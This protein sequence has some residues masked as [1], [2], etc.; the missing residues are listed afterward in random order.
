LFAFAFG[1]DLTKILTDVDDSVLYA[2]FR[3]ELRP[4]KSK[5]PWAGPV[6]VKWKG[7]KLNLISSKFTVE[8]GKRRVVIWD[9]FRF[10]AC[11]FTKALTDWKVADTKLLDR[12]RNMKD[13]RNEFDKQTPEEIRDYCYEECRYMASLAQKLITAHNEAGL[14]LRSYFGAGSSAAAMLK[15]MGIDKETR[16]GPEEMDRAVASAFFGGRFEN[17]RI[18]PV[19]QKL[20]G[21]DL[22]SAYILELYNL[23]CLGC[24]KWEYTT[25]RNDL[26]G[27]R[28]AC[29]EYTLGDAPKNI[30]WG[31]LPFR[32]KNGSIV[33]PATSGGGWVWLEEFIAAERVYPH[34]HFKGAWVYRTDC[35]HRPFARMPDWYKE[36]L[37]IGKEGPGLVVKLGMNSCYGKLA[38]SVG[39]DPPF[40]SP[41]WAGMVTS[42]CRAKL[43]DL[44]GLHKDP[45]NL[46]LLATDGAYT[47]EDLTPPPPQD[48]GTGGIYHADQDK[49]KPLGGWEKKTIKQGLF[50]ARP[51]IYF[52]LN[53]SEKD[54]SD[55]RARGVGRGS[56]YDNWQ[57]VVKAHASGADKV[58]VGNVSRF[59]GAK[60]TISMSWNDDGK[61]EFRRSE[62]YGQWEQRTIDMTFDPL[63]KREHINP[64]NTLGIR[65][66]DKEAVSKPYKYGVVSPE[67]MLLKLALIQMLEQPDGDHFADYE[68]EG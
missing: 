10:F 8:K 13:K 1:Y 39:I 38:Q 61:P 29:V 49:P 25:N 46:L 53:P 50:L 31:P 18:G 35:T 40:Q 23:P 27:A 26:E 63:P 5:A 4:N 42:G 64:D 62:R 22:S 17:S 55:M 54:I 32:T 11:K 52:P 16:K 9:V 45:A 28:A 7:Y 24:G 68:P 12:M 67:A 41:I 60:S 21:L 58:Q 20:W 66:F 48:T 33:F 43:I 15:I 65:Y 6:P 44:I 56:L 19:A 3:P 2:L 59:F 57:R 47:L 36:R 14:T 51:G 30:V 37:R 34:V